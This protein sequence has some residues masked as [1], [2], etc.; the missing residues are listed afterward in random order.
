MSLSFS[1]L[2]TIRLIIKNVL[3][4]V[5]GR[6]LTLQEKVWKLFFFFEI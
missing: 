1:D 5:N 6:E 4:A 3:Q 2:D